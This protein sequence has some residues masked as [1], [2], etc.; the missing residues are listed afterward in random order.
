MKNAKRY[1]LLSDSI[2]FA[3]AALFACAETISEWQ[4][5]GNFVA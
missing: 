1:S 3:F 5:R 2:G 4:S